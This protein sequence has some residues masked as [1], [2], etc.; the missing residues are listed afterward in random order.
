MDDIA[1]LDTLKTTRAAFRAIF[2]ALIECTVPSQA[3]ANLLNTLLR[4]GYP[5]LEWESEGKPLFFYR[6]TQGPQGA[7]LLSLA[8]SALHVTRDGEPK[9]LHHCENERC[10]LL[11]YDSTKSATRR[12]CSLSCL[13]RTRSSQRYRARKNQKV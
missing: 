1:F 9:R 5:F 4:T 12:W 10:I 8:L 3:D 11:F 6:T 2:S 7:M 13:E